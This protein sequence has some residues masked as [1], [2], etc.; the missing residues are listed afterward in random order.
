MGYVIYFSVI[1][2]IAVIGI[3][4]YNYNKKTYTVCVEAVITNC[5]VRIKRN[6]SSSHESNKIYY[7]ICE[8]Y[9][10]GQQYIYKYTQ[11]G[12]FQY[13]FAIGQRIDIY[14]DPNKP[15]KAILDHSSD[16]VGL[17]VLLSILGALTLAG[18]AILVLTKIYSKF[19]LV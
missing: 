18:I 19:G 3:L 14:I 15:D 4:L 6:D 9:Y 2:V 13:S 10:E 7:Y 12:S 11:S 8:Y 16:K 17:I 5:D 1:A